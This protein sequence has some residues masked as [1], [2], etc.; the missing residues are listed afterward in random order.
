MTAEPMKPRN[1]TWKRQ[2]VTPDGVE[3][4]RRHDIVVGVALFDGPEGPEYTLSVSDVGGKNGL[5][6]DGACR[7]ALRDF[8]L[9]DAREDNHGTGHAR[10][11]WMAA[12]P[13]K[14]GPCVCHDEPVEV[15]LE[16]G[17]PDDPGRYEWREEKP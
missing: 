11:F 17:R 5:P 10:M 12:D 9:S 1:P 8:N 13:D 2:G 4:W 3:M 14:R 7:R 16:A 6:G 15:V